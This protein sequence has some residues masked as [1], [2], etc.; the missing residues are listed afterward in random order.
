MSARVTGRVAE[1]IP[2]GESIT[3]V[4]AVPRSDPWV[5]SPVVVALGEAALDELECIEPHGIGSVVR[6][7]GRARGSSEG[8]GGG[9]WCRWCIRV[10]KHRGS[11]L[12]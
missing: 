6:E 9:L 4:S 10:R 11:G 7:A 3:G 2:A 5:R 1:P 8:N 12:G